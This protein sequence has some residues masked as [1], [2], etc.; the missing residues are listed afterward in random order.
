MLLSEIEEIL[1]MP[2]TYLWPSSWASTVELVNSFIDRGLLPHAPDNQA[3]PA[4]EVAPFD[5]KSKLQIE[6]ITTRSLN[7]MGRRIIKMVRFW[8]D[9]L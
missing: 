8:L 7:N 5:V 6:N 4:L 1:Y 2:S 3:K 9:S